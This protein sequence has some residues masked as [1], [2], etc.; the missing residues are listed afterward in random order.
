VSKGRR[1]Y[2]N[3]SETLIDGGAYGSYGVA[4]TFYAGALQPPPTTFPRYRYQGC[5]TF[6][7]N[8]PA[9]PS[10]DMALLNHGSV[11]KSNSTRS[12]KKLKIDP[13]DCGSASSI[14]K[15]RDGNFF[16]LGTVI[17]PSAFDVL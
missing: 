6:T 3:A 1:D 15:R 12:R 11:R 10:A 7:I 16:R 8:R 5:R 17:L 14:L 9:G 4:S 13:A 2:W